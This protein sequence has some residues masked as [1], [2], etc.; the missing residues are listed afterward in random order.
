MS[1]EESASVDKTQQ[2]W[3]RRGGNFSLPPTKVAW[4][5]ASRMS[6]LAP[7]TKD[8]SAPLRSARC[9]KRPP[10]FRENCQ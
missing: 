8:V 10:D 9:C 7:S 6:D 2:R 3:A 5:K 1:L 4:E